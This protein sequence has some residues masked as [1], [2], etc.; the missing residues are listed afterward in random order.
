[1]ENEKLLLI[2]TCAHKDIKS[3]LITTGG[4]TEPMLCGNVAAVDLVGSDDKLI[5]C[6]GNKSDCEF[7]SIAKIKLYEKIKE[8]TIATERPEEVQS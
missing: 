6:L 1:M 2:G 3:V 7:H 8:E 4:R 5:I